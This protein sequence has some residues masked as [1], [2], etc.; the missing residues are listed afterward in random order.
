MGKRVRYDHIVMGFYFIL[1]SGCISGYEFTPGETEEVLVVNGRITQRPGPY[2]VSLS[3]STTYG[4][5][6]RRPVGGAEIT[7]FDDQG[8]SEMYFEA[9]AVDTIRTFVTPG[10]LPWY[11]SINNFCGVYFNS[12]KCCDCLLFNNSTLETPPYWFD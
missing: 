5:A 9:A 4:S 11:V 8:N 7:L 6:D 10:Q 12:D 3:L 1:I 2:D